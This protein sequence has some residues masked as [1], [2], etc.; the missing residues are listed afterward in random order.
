[1][2]ENTIKHDEL[3]E[4]GVLDPFIKNAKE[5]LDVTN[6]LTVAFSKLASTSG[7]EISGIKFG[8]VEDVEKFNAATKRADDIEK[9]YNKTQKEAIALRK[10][11]AERDDE[12]VKGKIRLQQANQ[13]QNQILKQQVILEKAATGSIVQLRAQLSLVTRQYNAMSAAERDNTAAGKAL[14]AQ[15]R[16][17]SDELKRL[18]SAGGNFTRNVGNYPVNFGKLSKSV[19]GLTGALG[20]LGTALGF[21][22]EIMERFIGLGETLHKVAE[23]FEKAEKIKDVGKV[24]DTTEAIVEQTA[25]M[26][27]QVVVGAEQVAVT[28]AAAVAE[29]EQ[30]A[31]TETATV[32]Q[33]EFNAAASANPIGIII[34]A[35]VALA[36]ALY[37]LNSYLTSSSEETKKLEREN[38]KLIKAYEKQQVITKARTTVLQSELDLLKAQG[39]PLAEIRKKQAEINAEKEKELLLNIEVIKSSIALNKQKIAD[40]QANDS[41]WES[42]LNAS[43]AVQRFLGQEK[44]AEMTEALIAQN[45]KERAEEFVTALE[46]QENALIQAEADYA[47]FLNEI[48]VQDIEFDK[49]QEELYKKQ[50]E[51]IKKH[52]EHRA[53]LYKEDRDAKIKAEED[54]INRLLALRKRLEALEADIA[55]EQ[56]AREQE[57]SRYMKQLA[58]LEDIAE[59]ARD[60]G[61]FN[62]ER[63]QQDLALIDKKHFD[64]MEKIRDEEISQEI[65]AEKAK[66]EEITRINEEAERQRKEALKKSIEEQ[67]SLERTL[68]DSYKDALGDR[69]QDEDMYMRYRE[70][71]INSDLQTQQ[72]LFNQGLDNTL[73]YEKRKKEEFYAEQK[74]LQRQRHEQDMAL[75][76][77]EL[78]IELQKTYADEGLTGAAKAFSQT[79]AAKGIAMAIAGSYFE[80]TENTGKANGRGVDGRGGRLAIIHDEERIIPQRLNKKL[81]DISNDELIDNVLAFQMYR[82]QLAGTNLPESIEDS[83]S[84]RTMELLLLNGFVSLESTIKKKREYYIGR[85]AL[86]GMFEDIIENG[87]RRRTYFGRTRA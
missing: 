77:A 70:N 12:V 40:V 62:E 23:G 48:K 66:Q 32:A 30:A 78:F 20:E 74:E 75:E 79:M 39:A 31:A 21:N 33:E 47:A 67:I 13:N 4:S 45:K 55:P 8:S 1:M 41:L 14:L 72:N 64:E 36:A 57:T 54:K 58:E 35:I 10:Q 87:E 49:E 27:A 50:T 37:A 26:E 22:T 38:Q 60:E 44:Q 84:D 82:Q 29:V 18:E 63:Y 83:Y 61:R 52:N 24:E 19:K 17:L 73:A 65:D 5:A 56:S 51:R 59:Q 81:G 43:A 80:G 42:Y 15:Q 46:E 71:Q 28:E 68:I 3:I 86:K 69:R 7:K 85:D 2:A 16:G 25:A 11:L 53:Q 34:L 9:A 76:L 6:Q